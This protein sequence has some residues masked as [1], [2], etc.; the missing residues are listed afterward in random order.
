MTF[1]FKC[2]N[3]QFS[4]LLNTFQGCVPRL[5]FSMLPERQLSIPLLPPP[6]TMQPTQQFYFPVNP[7]QC[8][9]LANRGV[10]PAVYD[11]MNVVLNTLAAAQCNSARA[12]LWT[13][14]NW[15]TSAS[16]L[17][18]SVHVR[19][20]IVEIYASAVSNVYERNIP[21][22]NFREHKSLGN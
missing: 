14:F 12:Y 15:Y 21:D 16:V 18:W 17:M 7:Q 6:V 22:Q 2:K 20:L 3:F 10:L 19:G 9:N 5:K 4:W 8:L 11:S 13:L 1:N